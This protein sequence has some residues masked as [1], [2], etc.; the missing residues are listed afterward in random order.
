MTT[1]LNALLL[2]LSNERSRLANATSQGEIDLR[3]VWIGQ[4]EREVEAEESF[5]QKYEISDDEL[6]SLLD[7]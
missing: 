6:L 2:G 4:L 7:D 1:H 3:T 5:M